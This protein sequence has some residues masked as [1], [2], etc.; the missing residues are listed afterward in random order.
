M[1]DLDSSAKPLMQKA[2]EPRILER[3]KPRPR[4]S[5]PSG[6]VSFAKQ[7]DI[8]R[9]AAAASGREHKP[10]S[11]EEIS[12]IVKIHSGTLSNCN[13]F[14]QETGLFIKNKLQNVPCDDVF[15][16]AERFEWEP[17]KAALKLG[18]IV[19]KTWF[20]IA[21]LPKLKFRPLPVEEVVNTLAAESSASPD[22]KDQLAMLVDFMRV[23][24]VVSIENGMVGLNK[25]VD[26][27]EQETP[28][29]IASPSDNEPTTIKTILKK[30]SGNVVAPHPFIDG[31][32]GAL[33]EPGQDWPISGRIKW[34]Q[35]ASNI[36]SLMYTTQ[37]ADDN[38]VIS[39][40]RKLQ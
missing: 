38:E 19:R 12:K 7:L 33:P 24:G 40:E 31:L 29:P 2:K 15:A 34:L 3:V 28:V 1:P 4:K 11:N 14:F 26:E 35:T 6:R 37:E 16:Y 27:E 23:S 36:F 9:A 30:H 10:V 5:L 32:L 25:S 39:I 18:P 13:P 22:Y 20:A 21:L 8:L 17:E